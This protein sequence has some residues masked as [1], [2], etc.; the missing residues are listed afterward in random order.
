MDFVKR[1]FPVSYFEDTIINNAI[2]DANELENVCELITG[3]D[4]EQTFVCDK[5][6]V[7]Y[8]S[9]YMFTYERNN[10]GTISIELI[11]NT[12]SQVIDTWDIDVLEIVGN[13]YLTLEVNDPF[14]YDLY[15]HECL[16]KVTS[17]ITDPYKA[18]TIKKQKREYDTTEL[19]VAGVKQEGNLI[20]KVVGYGRHI[21]KEWTRI[22]LAIM[23]LI[24]VELVF[25]YN[26]RRKH[27]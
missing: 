1:D 9:L 4:V 21:S 20:F 25:Y 18:V 17:D 24:L 5:N 27:V 6:T 26:C 14:A 8:I 13:S 11:D 22:A 3:N 7:A 16:I 2:V 15:G 23:I 10:L 19:K 12:D